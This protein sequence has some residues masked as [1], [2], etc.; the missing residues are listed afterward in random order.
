MSGAKEAVTRVG[1]DE[2]LRNAGGN[3]IDISIVHHEWTL[4]DGT[5]SYYL[6]RDRDHAMKHNAVA[7]PR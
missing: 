2:F 7:T 6:P 5:Q 3:P 4:P 1:A